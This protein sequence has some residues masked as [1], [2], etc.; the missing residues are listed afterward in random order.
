LV[1]LAL[2]EVSPV[3]QDDR[4]AALYGV[5]TDRPRGGEVTNELKAAAQL[6]KHPH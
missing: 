5:G 1:G 6:P 3:L 4:L 2:L